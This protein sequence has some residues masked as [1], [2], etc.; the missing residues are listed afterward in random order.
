MKTLKKFIILTLIAIIFLYSIIPPK[1]IYAV[2]VEDAGEAIAKTAENWVNNHASETKYYNPKNDVVTDEPSAP[3]YEISQYHREQ[4]YLG[5][6]TTINGETKYWMDCV[7]FASLVIHKATGLGQERFTYFVGPEASSATNGVYPQV[8]DYFRSIDRDRTTAKRG[9]ILIYSN[10]VAIYLGDGKV[11]HSAGI[12][13]NNSISIDDVTT[14]SNLDN[15]I[16]IVRI[17]EKGADEAKIDN[18]GD[19]PVN[20]G[21]NPPP[22]DDSASYEKYIGEG[23]L[24]G[25]G[26]SGKYYYNS[27]P[28]KGE[29]LGKVEDENWLFNTLKDAADYLM[30]VLTMAFKIQFVG[31]TTEIE[32]RVNVVAEAV[33]AEEW[34]ERITVEDI[35]YNRVPILDVN[36]FNFETA[37]GQDLVKE[38]TEE[39][40]TS[41]IYFLREKI[42][43]WYVI[44]RTICIILLLFTLLYLGIRL[45]IAS[46]AKE[47]SEYK[48]KLVSWLVGFIIVMIIHYFMLAVLNINETAIGWLNPGSTKNTSMS[49][50]EKVRNYA[51]EIPASK[52]WTGTI[53]YIFLVYYLI[54]MLLFYFK[55]VLIVYIL[56]IIS[57]AIGVAYSIQKIKGKSMSFTTWMK[58]FAF[59][60]LI[61]FV[62]AIIYTVM[63]SI[64]LQ[65]T[66]TA[67]VANVIPY[68]IILFALLNFLLKAE[69]IIKNIFKLKANSLKSVVGTALNLVAPAR[70]AG[71]VVSNV[72]GKPLANAYSK[73]LTRALDKKYDKFKIDGDSETAQK[74]NEEIERLKQQ[75]KAHIMEQNKNAIDFAKDKL[76]G[77]VTLVGAVPMMFEEPIGGV[78]AFG[79]A[80]S[81]LANPLNTNGKASLETKKLATQTEGTNYKYIKNPNE[82]KQ[83]ENTDNA[84]GVNNPQ[85]NQTSGNNTQN[86]Q[87]GGNNPQNNQASGNNPQSN[88][89]GVNGTNTKNN[90][91]QNKNARTIRTYNTKKSKRFT[92]AKATLKGVA[93]WATLGTSTM[94]IDAIHKNKEETSLREKTYSTRIEKLSAIGK[95]ATED[96]KEI[97]NQLNDIRN[98]NYPPIYYTPKEN[99]TKTQIA[100]NEN[101]R[102]KYRGILE[103][104]IRQIYD[105]IDEDE[106][107]ERILSQTGAINMQSIEDMSKDYLAESECEIGEKFSDNLDKNL[108]K[109]IVAIVEGKSGALKNVKLNSKL[110]EQ[111]HEAVANNEGN[112]KALNAELDKIITQDVKDKI[113]SKMSVNDLTKLMKNTLEAKQSIEINKAF[114]ELQDSINNLKLANKEAKAT[115]G[116]E[117]Y[118]TDE[119]LNLIM[120]KDLREDGMVK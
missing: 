44:I 11:A 12:G 54:K 7:G 113:V 118:T 104:N 2:P 45:A 110:E 16:Y 101:L 83:Q 46:V 106:L 37:G 41:V 15:Y 103:K 77:V 68:A 62:H 90:N 71:G 38:D 24:D 97:N 20:P 4:A 60:V 66:D 17:T 84:N 107:E 70:Q 1:N 102:K 114:K 76:D 99:E 34:E 72:V 58:E 111:I 10:H 32:N 120:N 52:G 25:L 67:N 88:P 51:Y 31:W 40:N 117:L 55:R 81:N 75:E 92:L 50:Y 79:M 82:E 116:K 115:S 69:D 49:V 6:Q 80:V 43:S 85:N 89:A 119:L 27:L 35:I 64:I 47:K 21:I 78:P 59:N 39:N 33:S 109:K 18:T 105:D 100:M 65:F 29:Y 5:K 23:N 112:K 94:A 74:T 63:M 22:V 61:Q 98:N 30:G 93:S 53:I 95:V 13:N 91:G 14:F 87:S 8:A 56:A 3:Q 57:P 96:L 19:N 28:R 42:A 9:D 48:Q 26:N 36:I 108:I 73:N 86:N